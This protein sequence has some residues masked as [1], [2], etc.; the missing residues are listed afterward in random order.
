MKIKVKRL[1]PDAVMPKFAH[2]TDSGFD[3]FSCEYTEIAPKSKEIVK[4]GLAVQ[5]PRGY[6]IA[7]RNKSGI[8]VKGVN[9]IDVTVF[10]GT[11]DN[12][13]T[14]ELGIMVRNETDKVL[15]I[16]KHFKLA[17]GVLE[18]IYTCEFEEVDELWETERG[19]NGY[20]STGVTVNE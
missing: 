8:T 19:S 7:I 3:L 1:H 4:T 17:Q 5:L 14:G 9:G 2:S 6:G 18:K 10:L 12:G 13:Y 15:R 11:V 16:P 20:G